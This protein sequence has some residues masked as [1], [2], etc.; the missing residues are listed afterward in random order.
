MSTCR[1]LTIRETLELILKRFPQTLPPSAGMP[2]YLAACRYI[3]SGVNYLG[4]YLYIY[5]QS[6]ADSLS[7]VTD[8]EIRLLSSNPGPVGDLVLTGKDLAFANS[9]RGWEGWGWVRFITVE[10]LRA[11]S[12]I[13]NDTIKLRVHLTTKSFERIGYLP[14]V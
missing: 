5:R 7:V 1:L 2:W 12:F 10:K 14:K 6:S 13:E 3:E 11:G 8:F 4:V 9:N